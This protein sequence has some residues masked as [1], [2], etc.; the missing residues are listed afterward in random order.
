M[1]SDSFNKQ[2]YTGAD[3]VARH[4]NTVLDYFRLLDNG[5]SKTEWEYEDESARSARVKMQFNGKE[6]EFRLSAS[7]GFTLMPQNRDW[8]KVEIEDL[9][10]GTTESIQTKYF[11]WGRFARYRGNSRPVRNLHERLQEITFEHGAPVAGAP[12]YPVQPENERGGFANMFAGL[13]NNEAKYGEDPVARNFKTVMWYIERLNWETKSDDWQYEDESKRSVL[14]NFRSKGK[15]R[16][17]RLRATEGDNL[18]PKNNG[19]PRVEMEDLETGET[20]AVQ[21]KYFTWGGR[22]SIGRGN[23]GD[24]RPVKE[25]CEAMKAITD[26]KGVEPAAAATTPANAQGRKMS[27]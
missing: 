16:R 6:H 12:V 1:I 2:V 23:S 7:P 19:W 22:Y 11:T 27:T 10:S 8:P 5:Y 20:K 18:R 3:P 17:F 15:E 13:F 26:A 25:L 9:S 14:L 4:F 21:T 24:R